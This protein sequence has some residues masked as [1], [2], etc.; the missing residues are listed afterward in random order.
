MINITIENLQDIITNNYY[1]GAEAVI[2]AI[3]EKENNN[4]SVM[5]GTLKSN[6]IFIDC[7]GDKYIVTKQTEGKTYVLRKEL[8]PDS[9]KFGEDNNWTSSNTR[10]F[11]NSDYLKT[12]EERFGTEN[13][14]EHETDLFSHDGLRD[15]G[16]IKNKVS[17][18]TYDNYRE[19]REILGDNALDC[20]RWEWLSTPNSTP[21]G[22]GS[23]YVQI[24]YSNGCVGYDCSDRRRGVRPFFVLKSSIFVSLS[25]EE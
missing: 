13:I 5:L 15:C 21:S 23:D 4:N 8:L 3:Q 14:I 22:C 25:R 6:D 20:N 12:L 24:V 19:Q 11:L 17:L 7:K 16:K 18:R 10:E 2:S 9:M 1:K